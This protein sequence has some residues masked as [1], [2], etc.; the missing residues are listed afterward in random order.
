MDESI[1]EPDEDGL[2]VEHKFIFATNACPPI[3]K[4]IS[5]RRKLDCIIDDLDSFINDI[6]S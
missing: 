2:D 6:S 5:S 4:G 1:V 3:F